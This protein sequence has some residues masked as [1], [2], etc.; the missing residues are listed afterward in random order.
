MYR[1]YLEPKVASG[2]GFFGLG[3]PATPKPTASSATSDLESK[4]KAQEQAAAQRKEAAAAAAEEKR[5]AAEEKRRQATEAA[6]AK[7]KEAE[8]K[9]NAL[10]KQAEQ[11]P[12]ATQSSQTFSLGFLNFGQDTGTKKV[13]TARNGVPTLSKWRQ[14]GDGSI[15][16]TISG[17]PAFREGEFITTSPVS[18][19][20]VGGT[21]VNTTS[22][23]RYGISTLHFCLSCLCNSKN[24]TFNIFL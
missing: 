16:G 1:Y 2:G 23:S 4:K 8:E 18:G 19:N 14:N 7:R 13:A 22:G 15:S 10:A 3:A 11:K 24:L 9:R 20:A 12:V 17:S 5:K 21:Y 6:V